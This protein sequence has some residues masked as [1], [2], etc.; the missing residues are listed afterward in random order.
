MPTINLTDNTGLNFTASSADDNA[1]LNRYLTSLL[2]FKMPPSLDPIAN[3]LVKD[4]HELDFPIKLSVAGEGKFALKKTTL[5]IQA[6][7]SASIGLL[8]DD[9][10]S[11][12]LSAFRIPV[13]A[14]SSGLVSFCVQAKLSAEDDATVGDFTFGIEKGATVTLTSSYIAAANDKLGDAISRAVSALTIPHDL[15][16]LKSLPAGAICSLDGATS[17]MFSASASYSF[18]NDPLATLAIEKLP[19]L[20]I[21]ASA[22]ASIEATVTHTSDHILTI[23]KLPSGVIHLGVNLKKTDDFETSLTVSSGVAAKIGGQDALAFLLDRI[24]PNSAAQADAIAAQMKDAADFKADIKAAIDASLTTSLAASLKASLDSSKVLNRAFL[25]EID[26]DALDANS[27]P[28][29][30][31]ALTGDFTA[32]TKSGPALAGIKTLDSALTVTKDD[33]RTF[34]VHFFGIFNA[35]SVNEFIVKSKID[36]T[37]DTHELI[38]SDETIQVVDNNLAAE[39]LRKLVL[40]YIT[41]TLPASANTKDVATPIGLAYIDRQASTSPATMRQFVNVLQF[42]GAAEAAAAAAI[43]NQKQSHYGTCSLFLGLNLT[44]D[45][46]RSLFLDANRKPYD[47][48]HYIN[49]MCAVEQAIYAGLD[50]DPENSYHL[51]LFKASQNTW[52][53]LQEAG[54]APNI[55]RVLRDDLNLSQAEAQLAF[56]DVVTAV[57]WSTAMADYATALSQNKSLQSVGTEVVKDSNQGYSEPWMILTSWVLAAKPD[58]TKDFACSLQA[59]SAAAKP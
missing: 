48:L 56:T 45:Q 22:S 51:R 10:E 28:A 54:S 18:L 33:T 3:L 34:A 39:K 29:L 42:I 26:L 32:I 4:Q 58:I 52:K 44:P 25:Y 13:P 59:V 23:A 1:T 8:Q 35:A 37:T 9:D 15:D 50:D 53:A 38:L 17:L 21:N 43:F 55:S 31:S 24:N 7:V 27:T 12:C 20:D 2:T 30:Q 36:Y 19:P 41:L 57:W 6:G 49:A 47:A 46:C 40:K 5:E 14:S 16:D 11:L